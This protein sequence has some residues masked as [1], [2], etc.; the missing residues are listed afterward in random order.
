VSASFYN[1]TQLTAPVITSA[2]PDATTPGGLDVRFTPSSPSAGVQ[3]YTAKIC[4]DSGMTIGCVTQ[5][6]YTSGAMIQGVIGKSYF[7]QITALASN[8]YL[9]STSS[10][11]GPSSPTDGQMGTPGTPMLNFGS[12]AGSVA[13]TFTASSPAVGGQTYSAEACT[14]AN[15]TT[16]CVTQGVIASGGDLTGL[17]FTPGSSG[18]PGTVYYVTVTANAV[19]GYT[20]SAPSAHS[21][22]S[23]AATSQV[24]APTN[25]QTN[26]NGGRNTLTVTFTAS[27]GAV[28]AS[29][30]DELCTDQGMLQNCQTIANAKST[31]STYSG[32]GHR[33]TYYVTV[34]ALPPSNA[35]VSNITVSKS[36]QSG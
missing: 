17:N 21:A 29:Y 8:G 9:G 23:Q 5:T 25:V 2:V 7:A 11:F 4:A 10:V 14:N 36:G 32:L 34:T 26:T 15:M 18:G 19:T 6:S 35:Y 31:G 12:V 16:G 24:N 30:T 27:T 13:V 28:P 20:A 1:Y 22:S 33:S 3:S